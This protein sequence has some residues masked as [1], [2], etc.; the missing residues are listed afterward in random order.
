MGSALTRKAEGIMK[1]YSRIERVCDDCRVT[2]RN[3]R[4]IVI[5]KRNNRHR[6]SNSV[7]S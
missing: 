7:A 1:I 6:Q 2:R 5:C 4:V 3:G